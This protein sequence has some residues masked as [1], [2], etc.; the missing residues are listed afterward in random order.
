MAKLLLNLR[1]VPDDEADEIRALL[2]G[3]DVDYYETRPSMWGVSA[4]GI[5]LVDAGQL[6][7]VR[8]LLDQYQRQRAE[9]ARALREQQRREGRLPTTWDNFREKPAQ[10][11]AAVLGILIMAAIA[12]LPFFMF[13][14]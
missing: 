8:A 13:A 11:V 12:T 2:D 9:Q 14:R 3:N 4:G 10:A 5:W 7:A 1:N 6:P